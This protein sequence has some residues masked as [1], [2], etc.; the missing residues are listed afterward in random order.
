LIKTFRKKTE[1]C[2]QAELLQD[3]I[4]WNQTAEALKKLQVEWK[5][6]GPVARKDSDKIW[7]RF[8]QACDHFFEKKKQNAEVKESLMRSAVVS[9]EAFIAKVEVMEASVDINFNLEELKKSEDHWNAMEEVP[10]RERDRLTNAFGKAIEGFLDRIKDKN[11]L[12]SKLFYRLKYEQMLKSESGQEKLRKMR[13]DI[14]DKIKKLQA[15]V[16]QLENNLSF[17][18]KSKKTNP[19]IQEYEQKLLDSKQQIKE[20]ETQMKSIPVKSSH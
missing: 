13:F 3:S 18:S 12:D 14:Q 15:E 9:K 1:L 8:R 2:L 6:T 5:V 11:N 4:D 20:F 16:N 17:F 10:L 7:N 19:V